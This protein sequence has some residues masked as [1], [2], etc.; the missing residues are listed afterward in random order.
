MFCVLRILHRCVF[1][2]KSFY[3]FPGSLP[4]KPDPSGDCQTLESFMGSFGGSRFD[5][6]VFLDCKRDQYNKHVDFFP[7]DHPGDGTAGLR[8]EKGK[9]TAYRL[10]DLLGHLFFAWRTVKCAA[11]PGRKRNPDFFYDHIYRLFDFRHRHKT[12]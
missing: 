12:L 2:S 5:L 4:D 7:W 6:P 3:G 11:S 9:R 10:F 1:R 8:P